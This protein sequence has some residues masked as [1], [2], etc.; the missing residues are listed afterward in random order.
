MSRPTARVLE[1]A[2]GSLVSALA[3]QQ[4]GADRVELCE[5]LEIGGTTPS[6]GTLALARERLRIPLF[7]LI[8]PRPG[9]FVYDAHE[10]EVMLRD[11]ETCVRIGCDGIVA[12]AL[13]ADGDIDEPLC[14]QLL[15]AAGLLPVTFHRAFDVVSNPAAALERIAALGFSRLLTSGGRAS[16]EQGSALIAACVEQVQ[17]RLQVMPG[18]G[19]DEGNIARVASLTRAREFHASAKV[20]RTSAMRAPSVVLPGLSTSWS[21]TDAV[22]V[23]VL[24]DALDALDAG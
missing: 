3:A 15:A 19:L 21:E 18:G 8:R 22:R 11:I 10:A 1:I 16:A 2:A 12:G 17:G 7:V 13:D 9:D 24:R 5:A 4:G 6:Y 14:R 20:R 23:R